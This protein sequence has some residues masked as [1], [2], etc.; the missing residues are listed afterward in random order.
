LAFLPN[1]DRSGSV[2]ILAGSEVS[3]TEAAGRL[4]MEEEQLAALLRQAGGKPGRT[5]HFE[6]LIRVKH[7]QNTGQRSEIVSLHAH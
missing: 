6:A 4:L 2:L 5:P 3:G 1:L 7:I